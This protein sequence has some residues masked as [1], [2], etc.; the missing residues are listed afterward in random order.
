MVHEFPNL[1]FGLRDA[2]KNNKRRLSSAIS[3]K[4]IDETVMHFLG[5]PKDGMTPVYDL[6][7][8][9]DLLKVD[10][11]KH[12]YTKAVQLTARYI[13]C[14]ETPYEVHISQIVFPAEDNV[15]DLKVRPK[16]RKPFYFKNFTKK[17][18][19][20]MRFVDETN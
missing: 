3:T 15:V 18:F 1:V 7:V 5:G 6:G 9:I 11:K 2:C 4:A 10:E 13:I 8:T 19:I 17:K 12:I 20:Q 16:Q 14:N